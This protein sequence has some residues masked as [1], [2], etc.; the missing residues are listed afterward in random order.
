MNYAYAH[1]NITNPASIAAYREKAGAALSKHGGAL[2]TATPEATNLEGPLAVPSL[3]VLLS[4][5][6]KAAAL[7]WIND[8]ELASVHELRR[9]A[10]ESSVILLG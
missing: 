7:A 10:G 1:I 8:P 4:F 3:A 2:V 6:D 9:G 5:P